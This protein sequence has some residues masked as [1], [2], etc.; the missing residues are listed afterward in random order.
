M[1]R[2]K[3]QASLGAGFGSTRLRCDLQLIEALPA[4]VL[5]NPMVVKALATFP[6]DAIAETDFAFAIVS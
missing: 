6:I 5:I 1:R 3:F 2:L 4:N